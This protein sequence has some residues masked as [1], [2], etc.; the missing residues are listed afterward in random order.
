MLLMASLPFNMFYSH[1]ILVS[2]IVHTLIHLKKEA[3]KKV[4]TFRTIVLQSVFFITMLSTI[5]SINKPAAFTE[6]GKQITIFL[7]PVVLCL[8]PLDLRKY[9]L[10]LLLAFSIAS[11]AVIVYLYADAIITIRHYQLPISALF[12]SAFTNHNFSEPIKIH[13]TFFSMQI[14]IGLI[15][16]L[17]VLIKQ[18][19]FHHQLFYFICSV[20]L[21]AGIIQQGSKS[22]FITIVIIINIA[23]PWFLLKGRRRLGFILLSGAISTLMMVTII[24]SSTLK[25]RYITEL[26]S[27]LSLK[28]TH[29][30]LDSRLSR[31][32]VSVGLIGK[33]PVIGYGAGS[34]I[35]LLQEAFFKDKLY[36]SY[37]NRLNTHSQYLSFLIKSGIIGLLI[38]IITLAFGFNYAYREKDLLFFTFIAL[39]AIVSFSENLLDVDKGIFYYA[40]FF[41]FFVFSQKQPEN[42]LSMTDK[43]RLQQ[44]EQPGVMVAKGTGKAKIIQL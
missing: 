37:L 4:F 30:T 33:A 12:S 11:T 22:V 23:L 13:A 32:K 20:I 38:Y 35:G 36:S 44:A 43:H 8:N 7:F 6:W 15:Y 28:N 9:R 3:F 34:E 14:A 17:S 27:D 10:Q 40:F 29:A 42:S 39:I 1:L 31:W 18:R 2:F 5:Y 41:S 16:M 21:T 19:S 25:E 24:S 26:K